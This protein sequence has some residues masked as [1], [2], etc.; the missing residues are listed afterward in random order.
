MISR[1]KTMLLAI[2]ALLPM[3]LNSAN[4]ADKPLKIFIMA[5]QSNMQGKAKVSTIERL[6]LTEDSKQMYQDMMGKDGSPSAVKD[7]YSVYF[8]G[9]PVQGPL[10]PGYGDETNKNPNFGPDYTFGIYMQKHLNE[11]FLIIKTAWGGKDLLTQFR[12]PS[13]GPLAGVEKDRKGE[14]IGNFYNLIIKHVNEVLADPGKYHPGYN[15]ANGY[16]IAGF[17]WFQGFNDLI[18]D[19]YLT[20]KSNRKSPKDFSEYGRLLACLIRD[21]RKDLKAPKMPFV[22]G[23]VGFDGPVENTEDNQYRFRKAQESPASLPEFAGN[24]VAV[25][26]EHCWDMEWTRISNKLTDAAK[27]KILASSPDLKP[28]S[29]ETAVSKEIKTMAPEVLTPAELKIF[30]VGKSNEG[31]HYLGSAYIYGKIGKVMAEGMI[32]L[33]KK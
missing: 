23:V 1:I 21:V 6:N 5:G 18:S 26:T 27:K 22:I 9:D 19:A 25:R 17:V 15:P 4:A 32:S 28:K 16:E 29:L 3:I 33:E 30:Q 20:D 11:P 7:V 10:K 24:V 14:P 12:P 13:A 2:A 31:F 8:S